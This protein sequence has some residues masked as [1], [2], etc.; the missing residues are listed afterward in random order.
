MQVTGYGDEGWVGI[1]AR[2]W[3]KHMK[4]RSHSASVSASIAFSSV[5]LL[6]KPFWNCS[7]LLGRVK[8]V[9]R[10]KE[11]ERERKGE[12]GREG[13]REGYR[14]RYTQIERDTERQRQR[15][16]D[17][18]EGKATWQLEGLKCISPVSWPAG[19]SLAFSGN[20]RGAEIR[21]RVAV[22][23]CAKFDVRSTV[24]GDMIDFH[25]ACRNPDTFETSV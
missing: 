19:L 23:V 20:R 1:R 12:E 15:E 3:C 6:Y 8:R 24:G 11:A 16:R 5:L 25:M 13:G 4:R 18:P 22:L 17:C 10:G 9:F 14:E 21:L 7:S 2:V